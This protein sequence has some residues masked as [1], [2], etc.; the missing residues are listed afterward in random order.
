MREFKFRLWDKACNTMIYPEDYTK[1]QTFSIKLDGSVSQYDTWCTRDVVVMLFTGLRD[2]KGKEAYAGDICKCTID[3]NIFPVSYV[4]FKM[5]AFFLND[6]VIMRFDTLE[7]IGNI[8]ENPKLLDPKYRME[9]LKYLID[10]YEQSEN[11]LEEYRIELEY[12]EE[13]LENK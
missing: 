11:T 6:R 13:L 1:S 7:I 8:Y 5:G 3:K 10:D 9:K 2:R 4:E 12:L